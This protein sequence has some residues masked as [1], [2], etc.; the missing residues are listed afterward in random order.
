MVDSDTL[1]QWQDF[2]CQQVEMKSCKKEIVH[3]RHQNNITKWVEEANATAHALG[4]GLIYVLYFS[5]VFLL[6]SHSLNQTHFLSNQVHQVYYPT[7]L[8]HL[9]CTSLQDRCSFFYLQSSLWNSQLLWL[10]HFV[11]HL[12]VYGNTS[13]IYLV[14]L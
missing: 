3:A 13:G 7:T 1:R 11:Q 8:H 2:K 10:V 4:K 12:I 9:T 6:S 14:V 5:S